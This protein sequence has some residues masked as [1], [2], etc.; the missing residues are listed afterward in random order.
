M[1]V[2]EVT[3]LRVSFPVATGSVRV[4]DGVSFGVEAG[5]T[6]GLIGE[7][8]S[9]KS[10]TAQA[11]VQMVPEPGY[12]ESGRVVLN[13]DGTQTDL[14]SLDPD[15]PDMRRV[16][17]GHVAMLFQDPA[18]CLSPVLTILSQL[19]ETV[20]AHRPMTRRSAE[21]VAAELLDQVGLP[22][23]HRRLHDY[24]HQLS[25]G[26][27]Q[28]VALALAL[29]GR[30]AVLVADEPT[31]ALDPAAQIEVVQLIRQLQRDADLAV[32]F[33]THDLRLAADACDRVAVMYAGQIVEHAQTADLLQRPLHPYTVALLQAAPRLGQ[34]RQ[35]LLTIPGMAE[36]RPRP[37]MGCRFVDRCPERLDDICREVT[38]PLL[39]V[40][41]ARWVSCH[42][43][44]GAC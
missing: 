9:G 41:P 40:G 42:L 27:C 26:M 36:G 16:R 7:T 3:D 34:G 15:G 22:E 8:G 24:P 31:T 4:V 10:V 5:R 18:S 28:R 14:T 1:A 25:G 44:G 20:M 13:R 12:V 30:P 17:G 35:R 32:I 38:P 2:L 19:S 23:P 33:I 11:L 43:H 21:R 39:E 6:L 37:Q 29:A